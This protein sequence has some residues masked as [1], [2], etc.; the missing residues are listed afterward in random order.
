LHLGGLDPT[1]V[2]ARGYAIIGTASSTVVSSTTQVA[3][4]DPI[5][6]RVSDGTFGARV[7]DER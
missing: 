3:P 1:G 4:G 5:R 2:L 7:T 6:V